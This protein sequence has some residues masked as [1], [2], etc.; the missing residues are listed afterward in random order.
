MVLNKYVFVYMIREEYNNP[1]TEDN[2]EENDSDVDKNEINT[3]Q[4]L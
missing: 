4:V 3:Y 2:K 1:I